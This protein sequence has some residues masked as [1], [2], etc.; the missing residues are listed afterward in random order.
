MAQLR[1]APAPCHAAGPAP[2]PAPWAP[3]IGADRTADAVAGADRQ[4]H[5]PVWTSRCVLTLPGMLPPLWRVVT[6]APQEADLEELIRQ[7]EEVTA[8]RDAQVEQIVTLRDEVG[9]PRRLHGG[10]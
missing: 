9:L 2:A 10:G 8:E 1:Y 7:K 5:H 6:C 3:V 4:V